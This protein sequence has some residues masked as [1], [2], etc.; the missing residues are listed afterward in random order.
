M[1]SASLKPE[2]QIAETVKKATGVLAVLR[3][4]FGVL[5]RKEF[6]ILYVPFVR[7][8]MEYCAPIW[9]PYYKKDIIAIERIQRR[10]TKYVR[11]LCQLPYEE[12]LKTLDLDSMHHRHLR[13]ALIETYK[14]LRGF[15]DINISTLF[16][17]CT[18]GSITRGHSL[19][20]KKTGRHNLN[21]SRFFFTY[22][23]ID[24]WNGLPEVLVNSRTVYSFKSG[25][26]TYYGDRR[27]DFI[28][29]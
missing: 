21:C 5:S 29:L 1:V 7:S 3:R 26:K 12:R 20:L 2:C 24:E 18:E 14:L 10:A 27:F 17:L 15:Y 9:W 6:H 19:K 23:V 4:S 28:E 25:L 13:S 16:T 11:G 22:R 8:I